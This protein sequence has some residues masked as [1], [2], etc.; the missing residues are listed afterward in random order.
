MDTDSLSREVSNKNVIKHDRALKQKC[1]IFFTPT[2]DILVLRLKKLC[3]GV[4]S[5][6]DFDLIIVI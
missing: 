5:K 1:S 3:F 2:I 6:T 4:E